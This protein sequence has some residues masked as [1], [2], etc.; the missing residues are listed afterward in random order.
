MG[1]LHRRL[2]VGDVAVDAAGGQESVDV[3]RLAVGLGLEH[4]VLVGR[5]LKES[6][7]LNGVGD[8]GQI[9]EHHP[10]G[11][12]VGVAH[13]GV[14]HLALGETYV[15]AG[16][17]QLA[18]GALGKDLIQEGLPGVGNGVARRLVPE[19]EAVHNDQCGRSFTHNI[20]L[21]LA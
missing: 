5:I 20:P 12:D 17:R 21:L 7:V 2:D 8:L 9:L 19:A 16:G 1:H 14:A 15:Q 4:G 6:A 3:D 18:A 11:A 10:A 13:L